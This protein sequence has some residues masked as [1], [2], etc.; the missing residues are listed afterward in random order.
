MQEAT[1]GPWGANLRDRNVLVLDLSRSMLAP[2]PEDDPTASP[3]QKIEVARTAVYRILQDAAR[4]GAPFG[5]VTFTDSVRT[6]VPLAAVHHDHLPVI[7]NM[8]SLLTPSGRSAIWDALATAADLLRAGDNGVQGNILLVT[9]GWDNASSRFAVPDRP[10]APLANGYSNLVTHLLPPQSFLS[11]RIVGIGEG[12]ERDKGVD[13]ARMTS[14]L[15][16][17]RARAKEVGSTGTLIFQ[18]VRTGSQL[19]VQM[20]Q[21]FLDIGYHED[22]PIEELHPEELAQRAARAA[23]ALKE[24]RE[25]ATVARLHLAVARPPLAVAGAS[26]SAPA[27]AVEVGVVPLSGTGPSYL[28]DRYGPLGEVIEAYAQGQY[29]LAYQTLARSERLLPPVTRYYWAARIEF[30]MGQPGEAARSLLRAWTEA[31]RL[32][33]ENQP[34]V[35]RRL[36]LLQ[37]KMQNDLETETLV[38]FLDDTE[39]RMDA[40]RPAVRERLRTLLGSL[41]E[42]RGTYQLTRLAGEGD[43]QDA[44]LKHEA[45]VE[46]VFG[47]LQDA[48][49]ELAGTGPRVEGILDFVEVCLAE[50]R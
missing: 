38:R 14:L 7:E 48:R 21:A 50:M 11:L 34:Q 41:V 30:A 16:Q 32:P 9:D 20:V 37:A 5:I 44:A 13:T 17:L 2:M 29:D 18:E 45:A 25:H 33:P 36:A 4:S 22:T 27:P 35:A 31:D 8:V 24:P 28:K 47:R 1:L 40:V 42:L 46:Q 49:L 26:L 6:P 12:A 10:G 23:R 3:R 19:F 43:L 15:E 39:S